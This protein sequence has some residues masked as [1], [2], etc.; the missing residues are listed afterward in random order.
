MSVSIRSTGRGG[1]SERKREDRWQRRLERREDDSLPLRLVCTL[2]ADVRPSRRASRLSRGAVVG[3]SIPAS[4]PV[5]SLLKGEEDE[6]PNEDG[7][8]VVG[9]VDYPRGHEFAK[10]ELELDGEDA[11]DQLDRLDFVSASFGVLG[12]GVRRERG[13]RQILAEHGLEDGMHQTGRDGA[14]RDRLGG[15]AERVEECG[16]GGQ[17]RRQRQ[18]AHVPEESPTSL[19]TS[20]LRDDEKDKGKNRGKVAD[21]RV[22]SHSVFESGQKD[23]SNRQLTWFEGRRAIGELASDLPQHPQP[24]S[25]PSPSRQT[26]ASTRV[27]LL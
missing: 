1:R 20:E 24:P 19:G 13:N 4:L 15:Y 14:N 9:S 11:D 17:Q 27:S 23:R 3:M 25:S 18:P 21:I 10:V 2:D 16:Q 7:D 26:S 22:N 5:P 12:R 6:A 8:L